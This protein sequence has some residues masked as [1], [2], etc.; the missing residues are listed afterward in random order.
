MRFAIAIAGSH[1]PSA[2]QLRNSCASC[3]ERA[4]A[5]E[6]AGTSAASSAGGTTRQKLNSPWNPKGVPTG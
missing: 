1:W 2:T 3:G 6:K 5:S 4:I